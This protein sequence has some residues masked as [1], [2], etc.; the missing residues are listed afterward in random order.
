MSVQPWGEPGPGHKH[1]R[2]DARWPAARWPAPVPQPAPTP[3]SAMRAGHADRDRTVDVLKAAFAEGRLSA[4]E[5]EQRHEAVTVAQTYGQLAALVADLPAGPMSA[6]LAPPVPATFLP[7][8]PYP[9]AR[10]TN[11]LAVL[12]LVCSVTG[13]SLPAVVT[14]HI[15]RS[16]IR[17]NNMDGD[18]AAVLGL[19][20]GY[21]GSA[22][23]TLMILLALA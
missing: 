15:A 19:V 23:W 17:R 18:W 11:V 4:E 1:G 6:P 2:G 10:P 9:Q 12:S 8:P 16:Q 20:I 7:T 5:Y 3:Q 13:L 21:M 22:F 14:G